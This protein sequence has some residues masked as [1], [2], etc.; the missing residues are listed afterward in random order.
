MAVSSTFSI[1]NKRVLDPKTRTKMCTSF[2]H[3]G[4]GIC[5]HPHLSTHVICNF[6]LK[7]TSNR[8]FCDIT[9][10]LAFSCVFMGKDLSYKPN[11]T[12]CGWHT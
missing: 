3:E 4:S 11:N 5:C 10:T 12:V 6:R 7:T 2:A 8:L 1:N 9:V